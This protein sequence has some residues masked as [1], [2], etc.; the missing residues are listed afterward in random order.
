M[1]YHTR[2]TMYSP[3][4]SE[5][6]A[7]LAK[8]YK[9]HA[10]NYIIRNRMHVIYLR[11]RGHG[12][13]ASAEGAGVSANSVTRWTKLYQKGGIKSL[14][15][16]AYYRP[17]SDLHGHL[18]KIK[19][20]FATAP[21]RSIG[22]ARKR[23]YTLTGLKRGITQIRQFLKSVLHFK[24]R[25]FRPLPG[26]N[27]TMTEL[28]ELQADFLAT[29]LQPLLKRAERGAIDL[30]FVDAAHPVQGFHDGYVWS[31]DPQLI[32]TGSGRQRVNILGALHAT[33]KGLFSITTTDY[34]SAPSVV[35]LIKFIRQ[36]HKGRTVYLIMDNAKYQKCQLV[37]KAAER[38]H[39]NL[40]FL[41]P[42]SP[43]LNL[44]ERYWKFMKQ[45]ALAGI[46]HD[47]KK[48][49]LQAIETFIDQANQGLYDEQLATLLTLNFQTLQEDT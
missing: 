28:I 22:E 15:E 31:K 38:Y 8:Y 47:T 24:Y 20:N 29:T 40:V 34:I 26:G 14:L 12:P 43:N 1:G 18:E 13:G 36:E 30:F 23:I 33:T 39:I 10:S 32:R 4:I 46:Y 21:P 35:E 42:Y 16:L 11:A 25:K 45:T 9:N 41:P 44:I 37:R 48:V 7:M 19:A 17:K 49:F 5:A 2:K 3:D 27:K 6:D